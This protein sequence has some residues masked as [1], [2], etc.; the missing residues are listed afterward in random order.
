[1]SIFA[2]IRNKRKISEQYKQLKMQTAYIRQLIPDLMRS[3]LS[4][5]DLKEEH[6]TI[7]MEE[8]M[9]TLLKIFCAAYNSYDIEDSKAMLYEIVGMAYDETSEFDPKDT[10][11][12]EYKLRS[13]FGDLQS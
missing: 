7:K 11:T 9:E 8:D 2:N 5:W 6:I 12:L 10:Y 3:T 1:M 13:F 4:D